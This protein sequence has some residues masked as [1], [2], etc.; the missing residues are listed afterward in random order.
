MLSKVSQFPL[1]G[2]YSCPK[3]V[4]MISGHQKASQPACLPS[5]GEVYHF[6]N[7]CR[8]KILTSVWDAWRILRVELQ[9][10]W[11]VHCCDGHH[12]RWHSCSAPLRDLRRLDAISSLLGFS[13]DMPCISCF[14]PIFHFLVTIPSTRGCSP[15][16]LLASLQP[17]VLS[18]E[19]AALS[20]SS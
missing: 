11:A 18:S 4:R 1:P 14:S 10:G 19:S 20:A 16:G 8:S 13:L 17:Q 15:S 5:F 6:G 12:C 2:C 3:A 7:S 9:L